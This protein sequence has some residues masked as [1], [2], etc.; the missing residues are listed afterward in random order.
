MTRLLRKNTEFVWGPSQRQSFDALRA[1]LISE[2]VLRHPN[3]DIP[4]HVKTHWSHI[5]MGAVL[6]QVDGK[7]EEHPVAYLS[8]RCNERESKYSARRGEAIALWFAIKKWRPF[9]E[10]REFLVNSDHLSLRFLRQPQ[11]DVKLQRIINELLEHFTFR[12]VYKKGKDH[13]DADAVSRCFSESHLVVV[14][15]TTPNTVCLQHGPELVDSDP[16]I[17]DHILAVETAPVVAGE[18]FPSVAE[19]LRHPHADD[20][21]AQWQKAVAS[22]G[23]PG[24]LVH[25]LI[26]SASSTVV[27]CSSTMMESSSIVLRQKTFAGPV[28]PVLYVPLAYTQSSCAWPTTALITLERSVL[29]RFCKSSRFGVVCDVWLAVFALAASNDSA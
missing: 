10:G 27:T 4:F 14:L 24:A 22:R 12:V 1:A 21:I 23:S 5:A 16:H 25:V 29:M 15:L 2:P 13:V 17:F 8:R 6:T 3:F 9:L 26:N 19:I 7:C 28:T 11:D 20:E 18:E